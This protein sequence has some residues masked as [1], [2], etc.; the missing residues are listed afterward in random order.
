MNGH[1][2][3]HHSVDHSKEYVRSWFIHTSFAESYHS[4]FKRGIFGA[5]HQVSAKHLGRYLSEFDYR[6]HTRRDSDGSRTL[7]AIGTAFGRRMMYR[8]GANS[9][10]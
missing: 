6:W 2:Y 4:L 5:F 3:S 8:K 10:I 1:F 7:G 9:L